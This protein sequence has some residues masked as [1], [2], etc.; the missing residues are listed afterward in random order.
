MMN[1]SRYITGLFITLCLSLILS[2][3]KVSSQAIENL[4]N[5]I[6]PAL[7]ED[8]WDAQWIAHPSASAFDFGVY[9]F[10]KKFQVESLPETFI[11]HTSGD[12]RYELY[13]NG[14]KISE[15]PASNDLFSWSFETSDLA[16]FLHQG[17]NIIAAKVWNGG[18]YRPMAW[19]THRTAF[20]LQGNTDAE[21]VV[22][23][24]SSW[25]VLKNRGYSPITYE[26]NDPVLIWEY[27]VAGPADSLDAAKYPWG[28]KDDGDDSEDWKTSH[29][30]VQGAPFGRES[31]QRW[32]LAPRQVP[33]LQETPLQFSRIARTEGD[34]VSDD[35]LNGDRTTVPPNSKTTLLVDLGKL[36]TGFPRLSVSGGAESSVKLHY[37]EALYSISDM[38][39]LRKV[40]N[41]REK[42]DG[43]GI[44]GIYDIFMPDGGDLRTF[45]PLNPRTFRWIE[46]TIETADKALRLEDFSAVEV[47]YPSELQAEFRSSH[48]RLNEIWDAGWRTQELSVQETFVSDLYWERMQYIGDTKIQ[49]I[50]WMYMTTD[51]RPVR[52]ALEQF[53]RSRAY[54][55][56]TESRYPSWLE[57]YIPLYSLVWVTMVHDYWM[58]RSDDEFI[59]QF[60]PGIEQVLGWF[61]RQLN[62][63]GLLEPLPFFDYVDWGFGNRRNQIDADADN[64]SSA[65][66]SLFYAWTLDQAADLFGHFGKESKELE[67]RYQAEKL[68]T[69]VY[70]CCFDAGLGLMSDSPS[71]ELFSKQTNIMAVL[72]DA[73]PPDQQPG[74]LEL[75]FDKPDI[76]SVEM[77]FEYY[78]GR[79]LS[80]T[81]LGDLYLTRLQPWTNMLDAGMGT[82][83][84]VKVN[85]RSECH[86]WS[87]SP[88]YEFLATIA[89]VE[90]ASPGFGTVR[91]SPDLG[92]LTDLQATVP[93]PLGEISVHYQV[94]DQNRLEAEIT[95]PV[96]LTGQFEWN[97]EVREL[98]GGHQVF[99]LN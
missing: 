42:I 13:I 10:R 46:L 61:D 96:G 7:L 76:L 90:P 9:H 39:E 26:Q 22:N 60:L 38:E 65:V 98:D 62:E 92:D 1:Y 35:F 84:E 79:A 83:G 82:F 97:G 85:P 51:D 86:A 17:E 36:T 95:L 43:Q 28:W 48:S 40:K 56:L 71:K 30:I 50:L 34:A 11:N 2:A 8:Y 74:L 20:I 32:H 80:K 18:E 31:H 53:D 55:G 29:E 3:G 94:D 15:G 99:Q 73:I 45:R 12:N 23:T 75:V 63:D 87:A 24:D 54:F 72:T 4:P 89:G 19:M 37:G 6:N 93:H 27:Y 21:H 44:L 59:H 70:D 49:A 66:H 57:Q 47:M 58:H 33:M 5:P 78:L 88:N 67:F 69:N 25:E 77:Y 41:H 81:G 68:K 64:R 16:P 91:I 52:L 14:H